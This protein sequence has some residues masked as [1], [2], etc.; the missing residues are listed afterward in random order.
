LIARRARCSGESTA[1]WRGGDNRLDGVETD[2][3]A[4][5]FDVVVWIV[6][7]RPPAR[8]SDGQSVATVGD[9]G[10]DRLQQAHH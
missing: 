6:Q 5:L 7:I 2:L 1:G 3:P 10:A 9:G 8:G 4:D